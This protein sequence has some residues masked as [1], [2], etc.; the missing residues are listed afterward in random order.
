MKINSMV[1]GPLG[2]NCYFIEKNGKA[3][4]VDPGGNTEDIIKHLDKNNLEPAA[5][6]NTH[7]HFDHIGAVSELS[8]KLSIPFKI[9]KDDEFL[10]SMGSET[11]KMFGFGEMQIP[12]VSENIKDGDIIDFEGLSIQVLHTPGHS[13]GG[14]CLYV[15]ELESVITGDTLFLESIGRSD[16]QYG[17]HDQLISSIKTKILTLDENTKVYPGHGPSSSVGHEKKYNPFL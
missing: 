4:I 10:V 12:P 15:K 2:V 1:V 7:G 14:V 3:I 5:I 8:A 11:A 16:F 17:D 6:I 13:P 9:H